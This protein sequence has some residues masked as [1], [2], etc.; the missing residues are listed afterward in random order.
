MRLTYLNI[1]NIA[2][3]LI[4]LWVTMPILAYNQA[5]RVIMVACV[6]LWLVLELL[7]PKSLFTRLTPLT[8]AAL[9]FICYVLIV[10]IV[11]V[12]L[13]AIIKNLQMLIAFFFLFI[14]ESR[15][16]D[17]NSLIPVLNVVL[18][19]LP[20]TYLITLYNLWFVDA[21]MMRYAV[22]S[23]DIARDVAESGIGGYG[24][25]YSTVLMAPALYALFR[26]RHSVFV[27]SWQRKL[28][29]INLVLAILL[30]MSSGFTI[31]VLTLILTFTVILLLGKLTALR[32]VSSIFVCIIF[33]LFYKPIGL[34]TLEFVEPYAIGTNYH[35]KI[36]DM[37]HSLIEGNATGTA[38]GRTERWTRS[39]ELFKQYPILGTLSDR[40]IGK[41]S[42]ILDIFAKYGIGVGILFL[43]VIFQPT[44]NGFNRRSSL[45]KG[46]SLAMLIATIAALI[47]NNLVAAQGLAIFI[48][49]P[50]SLA[51]IQSSIYKIKKFEP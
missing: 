30:V 35:L 13:S 28:V 1:Q 37:K 15:K 20:I 51:L 5:Y 27:G 21:H 29:S 12:G 24:L 47:M 32:I 38:E 8:L 26:F 36:T 23:S 6:L 18:L 48:I 22:R 19:T 3:S 7:R 31:A 33:I 39:I 49:L 4:I 11:Q 25:A 44:V 41:H 9:F 40:D 10:D 16:K 34:V 42:E 14:W 2:I 45:L 17:F 46:I 43:F 50:L